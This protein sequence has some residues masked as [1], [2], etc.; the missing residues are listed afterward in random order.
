MIPFLDILIYSLYIET[1]TPY[2]KTVV[3]KMSEQDWDIKA[4]N[5]IKSEMALRGLRYNDLSSRLKVYGV[6]I[7][8]KTLAGKVNRGTFKAGF[9]FLLL[10]A[11]GAKTIDLDKLD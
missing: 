1:Y 4:R 2:I 10:R 11:I 3:F 5:L 8:N 6:E 9:L 7:D